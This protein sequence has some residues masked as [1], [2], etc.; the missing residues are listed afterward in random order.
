[1]LN[2]FFQGRYG[3]DRFNRTLLIS[4]VVFSLL[5]AFFTKVPAVYYALRG[6]SFALLGF[7]LFRMLSRNFAARNQEL[8]SY[9]KVE[10]KVRAKLQS[11]KYNIK[12][13]KNI[14]AER[15][16]YKYLRCPQCS[17]KLRVPR[18]KG[19]LRVTCSKCGNKF[20]AK[21]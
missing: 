16:Q 18:G 6:I 12:N 5:S 21:S 17:Q 2:R 11:L 20:E 3:V 1:M 15:K 7:T 19:K 8:S 13:A 9:L 14:R 10:Y 4:A